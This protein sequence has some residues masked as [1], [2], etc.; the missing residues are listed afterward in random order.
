MDSCGYLYTTDPNTGL[1]I[2]DTIAADKNAIFNGDDPTINLIGFGDGVLDVCDVYVTF[3][4]SLDPGL[5]WFR[6]FWTNA[7]REGE[8]GGN[9]PPPP[10]PPLLAATN[11]PAVRFASGDFQA[12][13][14]QTLQ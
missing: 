13:G 6:R 5:V 7:V 14:G 8:I 3:R 11:Q 10:R 1:L 9:A 12:S 4:R 2:A